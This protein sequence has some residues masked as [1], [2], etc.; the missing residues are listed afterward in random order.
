MTNQEITRIDFSLYEYYDKNYF[1]NNNIIPLWEDD[2]CINFGIC[3]NSNVTDINSKFTKLMKF[4][5]IDELDLLFIQE[6]IDLKI[7]LYN[8]SL[9]CVN[10]KLSSNKDIEEF[11]DILI[12]Y[13]INAR[14]SDIHI[15]VSNDD[16]LFRFRVDGILK[17]FF[18]IKKD[19]FKLLS[20]YIK[21]LSNLDITQIRLP[22][23]SRFSMNV[24]SKQFDF[25]VSFMPTIDAESIVIRILDKKNIDKSL[26]TLGL[27]PNIYSSL[28]NTLKLT[29]G[30]IL[31]TGPTGSGKTT[32]LYSMIKEL[33]S[34]S[35]KIITVEDP[36]E[37]KLDKIQQVAVNNKVGL[38]FKMILKNILRQDP[39]IILIGEIRDKSSLDIALQASLTGHLVIASIHANNSI[40]TISRLIDL[41]ADPFLLSTSLKLIMSQRLV[42]NYCVACKAK[43]CKKCNYTKYYNR[44][45]IAEVL[46]VDEYISSKIF[47]KDDLNEIKAYLQKIDF[48]TMFDDGMGK[49]AM[50]ITSK[51]EVYKVIRF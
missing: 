39:D 6:N 42:L 12:S 10:S 35:K 7:R 23:D 41:Q 45:C 1:L 14:S 25:R 50:N 28:Q 17:I 34:N 5:N 21:L 47:R 30:L 51:E 24:E 43:G 46:K 27:S 3:Q 38:S 20:S 29:Q 11:F 31:I 13:A 40:E 26:D 15:E 9:S 16:I 33:N 48:K 32:T 19:F 49:V 4:I 8:L 22:Q 44:S 37:Y 2:M 36:V 18:C